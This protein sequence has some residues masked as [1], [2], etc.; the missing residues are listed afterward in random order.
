ML[1]QHHELADDLGQFAVAGPI[2]C[3]GHFAVA[4]FLHLDDMTVV[5]AEL[6]AV[7]PEGF[8]RKNYVVGRD[9]PAVVPPRLR[10]QAV[11][12]V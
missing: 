5:G 9:R 4:G 3:E 1:R 11:R 10:A 12:N 6:R 8:E 2:E 7:F